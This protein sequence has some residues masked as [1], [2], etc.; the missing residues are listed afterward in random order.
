MEKTHVD[1]IYVVNIVKMIIIYLDFCVKI[2]S[3]V[4]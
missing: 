3:F 2:I 1:K 4:I